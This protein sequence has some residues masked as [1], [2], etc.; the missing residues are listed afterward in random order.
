MTQMQPA[1]SKT[2]EQADTRQNTHQRP[3]RSPAEKVTFGIASG[4][5]AI[6]VALVSY[7]WLDPQNQQPPDILLNRPNAPWQASGQFYI[8][9]EVKNQGGETAESVQVLAELKVNG[10]VIE[11]GEQQ[12][13]FLSGG[14]TAE[15]TFLFSQN[16]QQGELI[17]RVGS[18]KLP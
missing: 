1:N 13:D 10:Q 14:E 16:P 17:L 2:M 18:Y 5:L 15:G 9:F 6:V 4:I 7:T 3:S 11:A 12:I 8:P